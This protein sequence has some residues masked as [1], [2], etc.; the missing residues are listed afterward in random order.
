[1]L[2]KEID[3]GH[4]WVCWSCHLTTAY[5]ERLD[6]TFRACL[7]DLTRRGRCLLQQTT[8][9]NAGVRWLAQCTIPVRT[10]TVCAWHCQWSL[11]AD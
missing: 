4:A 3:L 5:I 8:T 1:L 2:G 6:A 7:A 11:Y 10:M 9:L